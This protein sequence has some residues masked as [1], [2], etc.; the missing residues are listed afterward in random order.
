MQ[1]GIRTVL[2]GTKSYDELESSAMHTI[3]HDKPRLSS[4]SRPGG[5]CGDTDRVSDVRIQQR[6]SFT[7]IAT[8]LTSSSPSPLGQMINGQTIFRL[9]SYPCLPLRSF[10]SP[11]SKCT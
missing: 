7:N 5:H 1:D 4:C 6:T 3:P 2:H 11:S 10:R 8:A 9:F